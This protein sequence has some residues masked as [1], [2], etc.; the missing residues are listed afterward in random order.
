MLCITKC[1]FTRG[2]AGFNIVCSWLGLIKATRSKASTN[3]LILR[4][5]VTPAFISAL[6]RWPIT[7]QSPKPQTIFNNIKLKNCRG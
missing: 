3:I 7:S 6:L 5:K 2:L 1:F 4:P